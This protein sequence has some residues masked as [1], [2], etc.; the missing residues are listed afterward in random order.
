[1]SP[2]P[3]IEAGTGALAAGLKAVFQASNFCVAGVGVQDTGPSTH[4]ALTESAQSGWLCG[5]Q[6]GSLWSMRLD[7][8]SMC[9]WL[10]KS[11]AGSEGVRLENQ[12]VAASTMESMI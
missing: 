4:K 11:S 2:S 1:M 12:L 6:Y 8:Y 5:R 9:D 7:P 10:L 3:V